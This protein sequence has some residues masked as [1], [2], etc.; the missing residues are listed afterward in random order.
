MTPSPFTR[1]HL[2]RFSDCNPSGIIFYPQYFAIFNG[3]VEDWFNEGL[4]IGYEKTIS[5]RRI[6][7]PTVQLDVDFEALCR[8]G[9]EVELSLGVER[10]GTRSLTLQLRC[11]GR[12]DGIVRMRGRQVLVTMSL[13]TYASLEI[14]PDIREA[15]ARCA[16]IVE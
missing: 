16:G 3:L 11:T 15:V 7:L 6:G 8:V 9:E 10:L 2:V 13:D 5:Q 12:H 1:L 14:P 4:G